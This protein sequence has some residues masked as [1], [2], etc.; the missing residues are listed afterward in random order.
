MHKLVTNDNDKPFVCMGGQPSGAEQ[1][2][3]EVCVALRSVRKKRSL[4]A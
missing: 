4:D 2:G 3:E 1:N